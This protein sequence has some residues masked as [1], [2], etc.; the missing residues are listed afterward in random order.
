MTNNPP[1]IADVFHRAG[2]IEKWGR[3]TN[4]VAEMCRAAGIPS[5]KY[6]EIGGSVVVTFKV[7][8]GSTAR[9]EIPSGGEK[10]AVARSESKARVGSS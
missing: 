9:V 6:E 2:L 7:R 8:A 1:I 4:R 10:K 3:G 5:P